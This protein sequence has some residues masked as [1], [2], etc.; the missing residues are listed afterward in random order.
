MMMMMMWARKRKTKQNKRGKQRKAESEAGGEQKLGLGS[1]ID[2][3]DWRQAGSNATR[4]SMES[5]RALF[6]STAAA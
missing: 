3:K 5:C 6:L 2:R 4:Q 1:I